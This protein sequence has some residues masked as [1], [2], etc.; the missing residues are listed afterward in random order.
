MVGLRRTKAITLPRCLHRRQHIRQRRRGR[1]A[2][3][4]SVPQL[5]AC[6]GHQ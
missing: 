6:D 3:S 4:A 5:M 2:W 1:E